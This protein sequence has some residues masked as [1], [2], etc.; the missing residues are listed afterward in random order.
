MDDCIQTLPQTG[1]MRTDARVICDKEH[2]NNLDDPRTLQQIRN[3]AALPG[4]VGSAW[5]MADW[6]HGYGFP[7]GG[8]VASK[9][10]AEGIVS[11]G[12]V[13][14]DINCGVRMLA[15]ELDGK[16][17]SERKKEFADL[18]A[19]TIPTG[20]SGKGG[21]SLTPS[22]LDEVLAH[23]AK[24]VVEEGWSHDGDLE[25]LEDHGT[26]NGAGDVSDRARQRGLRQLGTLGSGN[27]F[28]EVQIVDAV[29]DDVAAE[30]YGL[31]HGQV[32]VM[33]HSGSRGLGHQVC[34]DALADFE[35]AYSKEGDHWQHKTHNLVIQDRQ[36]A[37]EPIESEEGRDYI[38]KMRAAA[39]FA[40]ANRSV[41]S[42]RLR[43]ALESVFGKRTEAEVVYDVA[44]N[45]VRKESHVVNGERQAC[46][47]HRKGA[48]RARGG[49]HPTLEAFAQGV[50]Q[51][52]IV[53]GDMG[54]ASWLL[55]GPEKGENIAFGSSCHGAGRR[56]SRA[57]A[58]AAIDAT[59]LKQRLANKGII[60]KARSESMLSEEAPSAYK[61]VDDV[62]ELTERAGLARKVA[63]M[64]PQIV[65]KG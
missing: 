29:H 23:G 49:D 17:L 6:H 31:R 56:L 48:T 13:G 58:R 30:R 38:A 22:I 59:E 33:I 4:I 15:T 1:T 46:W 60:V 41:L 9:D 57:A 42:H 5:A 51:P 27:H 36:L 32:V 24:A 2:W 45:I 54:N 19:R 16:E 26:M 64:R 28:L 50:G 10:S 63:R 34:T 21:V 62:I 43:D 65:I 14:F 8:V 37:A 53:P 18:L 25:R 52:V 55:A 47:V 61:D 40:F 11:P 7:I 39:N 3:T 20:P 44:H 35:R 12:G